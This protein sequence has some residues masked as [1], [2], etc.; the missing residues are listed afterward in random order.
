MRSTLCFFIYIQ[1]IFSQVLATANICIVIL[2]ICVNNNFFPDRGLKQS[3]FDP[4]YSTNIIEGVGTRS[5]RIEPIRSGLTALLD[6]PA[7]YV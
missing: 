7:K 5:P 1:E 4:Q 2:Y 3:T 6:L